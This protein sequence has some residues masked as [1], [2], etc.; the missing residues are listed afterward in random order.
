MRL[1]KRRGAE[2]QRR[3]ASPSDSRLEAEVSRLRAAEKHLTVQSEAVEREK[4]LREEAS[5]ATEK[6]RDS[7]K[8]RELETQAKLAQTKSEDLWHELE[9]AS[10][11]LETVQRR[12]IK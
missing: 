7:E 9:G 8:Q 4:L 10:T 11:E 3:P 1:V 6:L 2:A 12:W 5:K